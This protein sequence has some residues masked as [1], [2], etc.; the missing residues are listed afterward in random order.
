MKE[1][2]V[3]SPSDVKL[4]SQAVTAKYTPK[5]TTLPSNPPSTQAR[6]TAATLHVSSET[7]PTTKTP[8][9]NNISNSTVEEPRKKF[10]QPADA[11]E[12]GR[13]KKSC[14]VLM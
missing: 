6:G 2:K 14:C 3:V 1:S 8:V 7:A 12:V 10:K 11:E 9:T 5:P 13:P 4:S